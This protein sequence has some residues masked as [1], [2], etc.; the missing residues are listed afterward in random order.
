MAR[1]TVGEQLV[2]LSERYPVALTV[3]D[4]GVL[5][6]K[7]EEAAEAKAYATQ[8]M[9][10]PPAWAPDLPVACEVKMGHSYGDC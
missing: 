7:E 4:S 2:V 8:V 9:S 6:V 1:I 10:T 3:H 5:I